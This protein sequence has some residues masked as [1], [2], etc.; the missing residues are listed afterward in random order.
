MV[1]GELTEWVLSATIKSMETRM[2]KISIIIPAHNEEQR[3]GRTLQAYGAFFA[4]LHDQE[5]LEAEIVVV[6]NGCSDSTLTVV[7]QK[8]RSLANLHIVNLPQAGKGLAIKAGFAHALERDSD[9]ISFVDADMATSPQAFYDLVCNVADYEGI[10]ASRYMRGARI[11]PARPWIKRWGSKLVYESLVRL[12]LG[13]KYADLQ[14]GAKIFSRRSVETVLPHL[15]V[16]QWA[17]DVE[18]LYLCKKFGLSVRE[19]PT[20][21]RDQAGSKLR[22]SAGF[23][24][25]AAIIKLRIAHVGLRKKNRTERER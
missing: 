19:F 11:W 2:K 13:L 6:L 21:W 17:F 1:K 15:S 7:Q 8:Q 12:L 16:G 5:L 10:I 23:D 25:L 20:V 18:L 9:F 14:C 22:L 4:D 24:M 3:I